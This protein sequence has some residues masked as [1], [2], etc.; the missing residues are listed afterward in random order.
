MG[1]RED[2]WKTSAY[3]RFCIEYMYIILDELRYLQRKLV[4]I[5][6]QFGTDFTRM[7]RQKSN[8]I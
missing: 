8:F 5:S 7:E 4:Q 3:V 6:S 2:S 1:L